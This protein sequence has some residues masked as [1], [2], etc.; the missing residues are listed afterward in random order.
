MR[1]GL[2]PALSREHPIERVIIFVNAKDRELFWWAGT[3]ENLEEMENFDSLQFGHPPSAF[4]Y[5][6]ICNCR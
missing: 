2:K 1:D 3:G 5:C 6:K 4:A